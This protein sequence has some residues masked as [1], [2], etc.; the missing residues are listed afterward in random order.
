V[1]LFVFVLFEFEK[2]LDVIV[3]QLS[4]IHPFVDIFASDINKVLAL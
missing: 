2:L 1:F 3:G 4:G